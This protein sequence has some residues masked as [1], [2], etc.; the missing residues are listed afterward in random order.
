MRGTSSP[1]IH[2]GGSSRHA[3]TCTLPV[4]PDAMLRKYVPPNDPRR[5]T[6][7]GDRLGRRAGASANTNTP[8]ASR[9][10]GGAV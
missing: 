4:T 10:G 7:S 1:A 3:S 5:S 9:T 2:A 8:C 6:S